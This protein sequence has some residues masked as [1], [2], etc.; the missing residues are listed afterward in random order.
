M[1]YTENYNLNLPSLQD[2]ADITA[3]NENF[4][5]IDEKLKEIA[6][7]IGNVEI[8]VD[9]YISETSRNPIQNKVIKQ[10]VDTSIADLVAGD[11]ISSDG[12]IQLKPNFAND[13]SECIDISKVYVLPDGFIYAYMYAE[14]EPPE[15]VIEN[16]TVPGY[17][18][19]N[20]VFHSVDSGIWAKKTNL[21]QVTEGDKFSYKG[22]ITGSTNA[23]VVWY[24]SE[25]NIIVTEKWQDMDNFTT[26]TA[27]TGAKYVRF[28]SFRYTD[29]ID[30]VVFEVEWIKCQ[31]VTT[32]YQWTNTGH[33]F[34]PAD[35]ETVITDLSNRVEKLEEQET[36]I[37]NALKG[38]KIVYDGD[39]IC[40]SRTDNG[41]AY[42]KLI[43]DLTGCTAVNEGVSGAR[44]TTRTDGKHS[45]VDNLENLP[46]NADLYCFEGGVNDVWTGTPLGTYSM[47]DYTGTVDETTICGALETIF[48]YALNNFV[49]KP[50]CFI[51]T[52]KVSN[53]NF[54]NYKNFHDSAVAICNKYSI[55]YYDAYNE[56]G[57]NGWNTAQSNAFLTGNAT[58]T[59]D[60]CHPNEEG[61]KRYYVPQLISL[62]EK[63]MPR[64]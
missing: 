47:S 3:L 4:S 53:I 28:Y 37:P 8:D 21:I 54:D 24:D 14:T 34:V 11:G 59:P 38:K 26:Y 7:A 23:S 17:W 35:Y 22:Y 51:I 36:E 58:N 43:E 52:H 56:S 61:Y 12:R 27:P 45:V 5:K 19:K 2:S 42:A 44:L 10:Y 29:S 32:N 60:G 18:D 6:E 46:K 31:A 41:G 39:S 16:S 30:K 25:M 63:I 64:D 40:E 15:I 50:I 1:N 55:P 48:R 13:I 62:F 49:G 57:L 9:S 20:D 33:A